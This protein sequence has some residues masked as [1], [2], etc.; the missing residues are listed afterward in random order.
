MQSIDGKAKC[1]KILFKKGD[2]TIALFSPIGEADMPKS[3]SMKGDMSVKVGKEYVVSGSL[4]TN[5]TYK[6][7]YDALNIRLDIDLSK[8]D[9]KSIQSFL[10]NITSENRAKAIVDTLE[11]PIAVLEA[12]DVTKISTIK[13]IGNATAEKIIDGYFS[14]KDYSNAFMELSEYGLTAKAIKKISKYY[15]NPDIAVGKIK[16]NPYVLTEVDGYGFTKA[17]NI[18]LNSPNASPTDNRRVHAYIKFMFDK[19]EED[20]NSWITPKQFITQLKE[21]IPQADL[22]Y[23]VDYVQN[24]SEYVY[25]NNNG[26]KR[27]TTKRLYKIEE[28]IA[29]E[30]NRLMSNP[31]TMDLTG[32][33]KSVKATEKM[34]GFNYSEEQMVAIKNMAEKNVYMLQGLAGAGKSTTVKAFLNAVE[35]SGYKYSQCALSGKA[36]ENLSQITGKQG[37]TIHSLL[38]FNTDT[39]GYAFNDKNRLP[40]NVVVLDEISMV[41]AQIFLSLLKAIKTGSKLIMIGDY[42][43]LESIGLGVM[44]GMIS[45]KRIPM[46]LLKKIHRQAQDSAIITHSISVRNGFKPK[47]L[48]LKAG[49]GAVYGSR[50]DLEYVLVSKEDED[51]VLGLTVAEFTKALKKY[52]I[53]DVQILCSTRKSGTVSTYD[54]NRLAQ[55][56]YNRNDSE[57][58]ELGYKNSRYEV[59]VGDKVI[60]TKNNKSTLTPDGLIKPIY[61]GNTGIVKEIGE[62]SDGNDTMTIDFDGIGEVIV[63]GEAIKN[64]ELGYAITVHKSQGSTIKCVIFALPFHYLLNTKE[65][66]YTGMTRASEY[67]VLLTSPRS[68]KHAVKNTSVSKKKVN[69]SQLIVEKFDN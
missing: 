40:A 11:D 57:G 19:Q 45:S 33:E 6:D 38:G 26:D 18:F 32:Y 37:Y 34:N 52:D 5:T 27:I 41:N 62:D 4:D 56:V 51:S 25:I 50:E 69:L 9:K 58:I 61:N 2:F 30:L 23:A 7:S 10:E 47:E 59:R 64:I 8:K 12:S 63:D 49:R 28:Q 36:A 22:R 53:N 48:E 60:N 65:L 44:G 29:E 14:Q 16:K 46:T 68:F 17:D 15:G 21:F 42:G 66:V 3:F 54:L 35:A 20:G 55:K 13:G 43:Q 1:N 39:G 24:D 31:T 67:Q